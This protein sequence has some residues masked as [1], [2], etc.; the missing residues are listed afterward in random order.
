MLSIHDIDLTPCT[1]THNASLVEDH[2]EL[3]VNV[4]YTSV[5]LGASHV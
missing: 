4:P 5:D 3:D 2:D 1:A